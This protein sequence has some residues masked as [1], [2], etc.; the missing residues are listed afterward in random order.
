MKFTKK[1]INNFISF[2]LKYKE[3]EEDFFETCKNKFNDGSFLGIGRNPS[4]IN[5]SKIKTKLKI[6]SKKE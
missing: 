5:K 6:L 3:Y 2:L 1:F 4:I